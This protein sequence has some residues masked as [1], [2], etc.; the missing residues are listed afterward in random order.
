MGRAGLSKIRE[1]SLS[2]ILWDERPWYFLFY[3]KEIQ[4][5][6]MK[7]FTL[8]IGKSMRKFNNGKR[9]KNG[10][11]HKYYPLFSKQGGFPIEIKTKIRYHII[12]CY[13]NSIR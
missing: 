2:A 13:H 1:S 9:P 7:V 3:T 12:C 5:T 4:Y 10:F 8:C 11:M 6:F